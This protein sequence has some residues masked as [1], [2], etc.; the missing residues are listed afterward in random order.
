MFFKSAAYHTESVAVCIF[1][2][3][4]VSL[5]F[6]HLIFAL[7]WYSSKSVRDFFINVFG[8]DLIFYCLGNPWEAPAR[9]VRLAT[10]AFGY[11]VGVNIASEKFGNV[12]ADQSMVKFPDQTLKDYMHTWNEASDKFYKRWSMS[13][14]MS[15]IFTEK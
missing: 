14:L 10:F 6:E 7:V 8:L 4:Y 13:G 5:L 15:K 2:I 12:A 9:K 11:E 3:F 1:F